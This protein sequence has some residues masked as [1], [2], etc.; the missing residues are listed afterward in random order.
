M[1]DHGLVLHVPSRSITGIMCARALVPLC[2][3]FGED[4]LCI[5]CDEGLDTGP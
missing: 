3:L 2:A 5:P 4:D 1:A